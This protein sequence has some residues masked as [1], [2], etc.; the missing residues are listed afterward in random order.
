MKQNLKVSSWNWKKI[1]FLLFEQGETI[2]LECQCI[3]WLLS[4]YRQ[5]KIQLHAV[6]WLIVPRLENKFSKLKIYTIV[7]LLSLSLLNTKQAW[8]LWWNRN[9]SK[10]YFPPKENEG[11][12]VKFLKDQA[13]QIIILFIY[14]FFWRGGGQTF[15]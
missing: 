4:V 11:N 14:F 9:M 10:V 1:N 6:A 15:S 12:V 5:W 2:L 3:C 13:N 7:L 8:Y